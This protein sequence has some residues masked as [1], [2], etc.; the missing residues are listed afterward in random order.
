MGSWAILIAGG[1]G[2][3]PEGLEFGRGGVGEFAA[4]LGEGLLYGAE[5]ALEVV[6]G[7]AGVVFGVAAGVLGLDCQVEGGLAGVGGFV[8]GS[9]EAVSFGA[10]EEGLGAGEGGHVAWDAVE[11]GL[12][13][14]AFAGLEAFPGAFEQVWGAGFVVGEDVGVA[15]DEFGADA[16]GDVAEVE[17]AVLFG[18][19][20]VE[21]DL[22]EEV[23][24]FFAEFGGGAVGDGVEDFVGF[25][26]QVGAEAGVGL[27]EVPGAAVVGVAEAVD[28]GAEAFG[29]VADFGG[30]EGG[31]DQGDGVGG[32]FG[33][34]LRRR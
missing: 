10:A 21:D 1:L 3:A 26:E 25:L 9:A 20:G 30:L 8:R 33:D 24:E 16:F 31:E 6:E 29:V 34:G 11:D 14:G 2:G 27:G 18:D 22:E 13:F 4:G 19:F 23:A 7:V 12:A 32:R 28:D 5:A 17:A 15:S